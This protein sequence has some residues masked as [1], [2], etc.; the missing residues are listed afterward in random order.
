MSKFCFRNNCILSSIFESGIV[1]AKTLKQIAYLSRLNIEDSEMESMLNDFNR[2]MEYVGQVKEL[3][4]S[5]VHEEDIYSTHENFTREDII[6]ESL[7]IEE[8]SNVSPK[9]ENGYVVVPRVIE[10]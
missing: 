4:T 3:D 2:I 7:S 9:F 6:G 10:T 1:D 8:I 5:S